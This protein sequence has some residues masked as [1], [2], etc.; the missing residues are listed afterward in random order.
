MTRKFEVGK[1]YRPYDAGFD[2][3]LITRRTEKT[4][5]CDNGQ[6]KWMMRVK[7]DADGNEYAVDSAY[8]VRWRYT[9][10]YKA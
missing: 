4:I 5:W 8:P 9:L 3:I 1:E 7:K 6:S 10:T 2:P